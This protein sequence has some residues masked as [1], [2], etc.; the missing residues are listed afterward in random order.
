VDLGLLK[1]CRGKLGVSSISELLHAARRGHAGGASIA[2]AVGPGAAHQIL[3]HR[4]GQARQSFDEFWSSG[5]TRF[6]DRPSSADCQLHGARSHRRRRQS[7]LSNM[8]ANRPADSARHRPGHSWRVPADNWIA[9]MHHRRRV[10]PRPST[11]RQR[12]DSPITSIS[13][14]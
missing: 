10:A 3:Q 12:K 6:H 4:V 1:Q 7:I 5:A 14:S 9:K 13:W 8:P 11:A 2:P